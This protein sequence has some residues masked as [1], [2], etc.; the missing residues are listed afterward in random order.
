[1]ETPG[2]EIPGEL[3]EIAVAE[4]LVATNRILLAV[5]PI[6]AVL[7]SLRDPLIQLGEALQPLETA[8]L[9]QA[10][11]HLG[12][13][14][15]IKYWW[16]DLLRLVD[17]IRVSA[18][19][20]QRYAREMEQRIATL[21]NMISAARQPKGEG[22]A[23]TAENSALLPAA[24][25]QARAAAHLKPHQWEEGDP[26]HP[27][28][29][30]CVQNRHPTSRTY[31]D[32]EKADRENRCRVCWMVGHRAYQT[33]L[34]TALNTAL[35]DG[36]PAN[37]GSAAAN[38]PPANVAAGRGRSRGRGRGSFRSRGSGPATH[39]AGRGNNPGATRG[40]GQGGRPAPRGHGSKRDRSN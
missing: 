3:N 38:G 28:G 40:D 19:S 33:D 35:P 34:C 2:I 11:F 22:T 23:L 17:W 1:M 36:P 30:W 37:Q 12:K 25:L 32:L 13:E 39:G 15:Q 16:A 10:P 7:H 31:A 6:E 21:R 18:L 24:W 20:S 8:T 14:D 26:N 29:A 27:G 4:F 9:Q 5:D